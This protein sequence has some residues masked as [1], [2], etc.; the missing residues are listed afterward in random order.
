MKQSFFSLH[1]C[2]GGIVIAATVKVGISFPN[3][4]RRD[5]FNLILSLRIYFLLSAACKVDPLGSYKAIKNYVCRIISA[6]LREQLFFLCQFCPFSC[7]IHWRV[8]A[9]TSRA[10]KCWVA[11]RFPSLPSRHKRPPVAPQDSTSLSLMLFTTPPAVP[12]AFTLGFFSSTVN[13]NMLPHDFPRRVLTWTMF[14]AHELSMHA[15][16]Q[17][18]GW[19]YCVFIASYFKEA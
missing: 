9:D 4:L 14:H 10:S 1:E 15:S 7:D 18:S 12:S 16:G 2:C 19:N 8:S 6:S 17:M 5:I 13:I 11:F 3:V